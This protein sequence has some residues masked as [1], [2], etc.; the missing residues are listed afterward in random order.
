MNVH[1]LFLIPQLHAVWAALEKTI[2]Q[3]G[4]PDVHGY[5]LCPRCDCLATIA[6]G[7]RLW[8]AQLW[9]REDTRDA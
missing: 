2:T 4:C 8:A 6:E 1:E 5:D 9:H 3:C 7:A